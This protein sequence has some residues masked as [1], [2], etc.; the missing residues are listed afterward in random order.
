[1]S[2]TIVSGLP[3]AGKTSVARALAGRRDRGVHLDTD[4]IG[5]RFVVTGLVLPGG[6]P[7]DESEQQLALRRRN[8]CA[9][10]ANFAADGF[11]VFVSDVVLWPGLLA[12]YARLLGG[13]PRLVILDPDA[14][15]IAAR[16]AGRD[17]QVAAAWSYLKADLDAWTDAPGLRLDSTGL[18]LDHTV[19][20]VDAWLHAQA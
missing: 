12:D 3:G 19:D 16:D 18:D 14:A 4:D 11:D 9:L 20:A 2:V 5:E 8:L 15:S 1:M 17:K 13:E 7:A 6:D 10:A